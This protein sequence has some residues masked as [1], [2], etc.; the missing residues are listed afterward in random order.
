MSR[1][2]LEI[3]SE[4]PGHGEA[5]AEALALAEG[6]PPLLVEADRVAAAVSQG[7]H[8]R[9]RQG[10]GESYWQHRPYRQED[11]YGDIDWRQSARS[12]RLYVR[13][14]E[15]EAA[16][17]VWIWRSAGPTMDYRS[18]RSGPTKRRRAD[19]LAVALASLLI[20]AEE[21]VARLGSGEAPRRGRAAV[22]RLA[23]DLALGE[24]GGASL[25]RLTPPRHGRAVLI[26][27]FLGAEAMEDE[28]REGQRRRD[29]SW[30]AL[31]LAYAQRGVRGH[32]LLIA[33]PAEEDFP[34][35]GRVKFEDAQGDG[36]LLFGRAESAATR[37]RSLWRERLA[38]LSDAAAAAGWT[39]AAHRT[40]R[41]ASAAL[42][43]L[44]WAIAG[45]RASGGVW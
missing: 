14:N 1:R 6:L 10:F 45:Q 7:V 16:C 5:E 28:G 30:R 25:R 19:V 11:G 44:Y 9:R 41:P 17:S 33:D 2:T 26:G 42:L 20:R 40:D 37:Y 24:E 22:E 39:F 32:A 38:D 35:L 23:R 13:E 12:D 34:F 43:S 8:G 29:E 4:P 18:G 3:R 21:H 36:P 27:D 15:W 31:F